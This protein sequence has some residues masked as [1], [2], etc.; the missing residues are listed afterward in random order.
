MSR[1]VSQ[2][3]QT[4]K[5]LST[6]LIA[7]IAEVKAPRPS[8]DGPVKLGGTG[9]LIDGKGWLVTN[10]HVV[11][12]AKAVTVQNNHGQEFNTKVVYIDAHADLAFLKVTD[13]A[14]LSLSEI[15][16]MESAN[17]AQISENK[18]LRLAIPGMKLF[19]EKVI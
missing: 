13:D 11:N 5:T 6:T 18:F 14:H 8:S 2:L 12:N 15:Y 9:F 19:M 4:Q 10:A 1:K 3:E 17:P 16:L 7:K